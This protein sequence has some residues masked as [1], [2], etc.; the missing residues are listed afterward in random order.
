V[1][2]YLSGLN[3]EG[4]GALAAQWGLEVVLAILTLFIGSKIAN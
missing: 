3:L 4:F 1:N 2:S